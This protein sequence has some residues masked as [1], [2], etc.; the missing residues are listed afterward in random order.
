MSKFEVGD[1]VR[2]K[3][4]GVFGG[5]Y[6]TATIRSFY[7]GAKDRVWLKETDTHIGTH[8]LVPAVTSLK[9]EDAIESI[10]VS[11]DAM[12]EQMR[13]LASSLLGEDVKLSKVQSVPSGGWRL[14]IEYQ[15]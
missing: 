4:D 6:K 15:S 7:D 12:L 10:T 13:L 5:K 3:K 1:K 14:D 2:L 9:R 8:L 11:H